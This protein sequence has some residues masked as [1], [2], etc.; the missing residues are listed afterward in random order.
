MIANSLNIRHEEAVLAQKVIWFWASSIIVLLALIIIGIVL[1]FSRYTR[2]SEIEISIQS[3]KDRD[4]FI[5]VT[6]NVSM[7]GLYPFSTADT[8]EELLRDAGG[9]TSNSNVELSLNVASEDTG[10]DVQKID[11]NRA[12][13]WLLQALPGIGEILSQRIVDYRKLNGPFHNSTELMKVAGISD[14]T[15]LKIQDK[16]T[17]SDR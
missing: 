13:V 7:P 16:I 9:F 6:G 3:D 14:D 11:I 8:I 1:A 17:I 5:Y 12:D 10:H 4:S 15:L 2:A